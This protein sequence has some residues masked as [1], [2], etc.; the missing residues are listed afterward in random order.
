LYSDS[1]TTADSSIHVFDHRSC[2][3]ST[4]VS[5]NVFYEDSE[6]ICQK[7]VITPEKDESNTVK[8]SCKIQNAF[9]T[10]VP[11]FEYLCIVDKIIK[12]LDASLEQMNPVYQTCERPSQQFVCSCQHERL[13]RGLSIMTCSHDFFHVYL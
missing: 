6:M 13:P 10:V 9:L 11:I 7:F 12:S 5:G 8:V 2:D 3:E 1:A 4:S